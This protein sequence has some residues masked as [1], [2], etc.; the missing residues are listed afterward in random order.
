MGYHLTTSL[1]P[2]RVRSYATPK[3]HTPLPRLQERGHRF[4]STEL[5]RWISRDPIGEEGGLSE[6]VFVDGNAI[7]EVDVLG[8]R[9]YLTRRLNEGV[10][11]SGAAIQKPDPPRDYPRNPPPV[12]PNMPTVPEPV[13]RNPAPRAPSAPRMPG[14]PTPGFPSEGYTPDPG[15]IRGANCLCAITPWWCNSIKA[16]V[17]QTCNTACRTWCQHHDISDN[18][19]DGWL[20]VCVA[21]CARRAALC[22][23]GLPI[24]F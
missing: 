24:N 3:T 6:Y 21:D 15:L 14:M 9:A 20:P 10:A 17:C 22:L 1:A 19:P 7:G 23:R 2:P 8:D 18:M 12:D 13:P 4:Y 5:S 11:G 16:S